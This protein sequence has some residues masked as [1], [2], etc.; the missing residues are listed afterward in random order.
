M[1]KHIL[2]LLAFIPAAFS[3]FHALPSDPVADPAA[4]VI[5]GKVRF[6]ILTP[7]TIRMEWSSDRKFED[8][9]SLTFINRKLPVPPY[10]KSL[11]NGWLEIQT[12]KLMIRYK[13]GS[14]K[15]TPD[16]LSIS[17]RMNGKEVKWSPGMP[18]NGNLRG[19]TRTLDGCDGDTR[20]YGDKGSLQLD[21]GI[22]SRDGWALVDDSERPLFDNSDWPWVMERSKKEC[23]DWYFFGYGFDYKTALADFTEISGNIAFPPRFAFGAWWSRYW[24]YTD[25]ELRDLVADFA[26]HQIPLDVLIV[27]MD[28]HITSLPEF[29]KD[30]K[31]QTDQAGESSGWTGLTWNKNYFPDPKQFLDWTGKQHLKTAL[32]LHPASGIQPHEACYE[33][34]AKAMGIDPASKKYVP[35]D[36]TDKTFARNYMDIIMHPM[37]KEGIDFWWLDWQQWGQTKIKGVNPTFYLN[38]VFF[39]DM[40]RMGKS[41][42]LLFHRYGGL[43]NHRYQI[44]F[45]GDTYITWKSL[46]YQPYFTLTAANV[47]YGYWSH[48]IGGHQ[49]GIRS[50]ELYT[51]WLQWGAFSPIL[52]THCTKNSTI[53][54]RIWAYAPEY[55][56]PMRNA[57]LWRYALV[58]YIYTNAH[59]AYET[60]ISLIH[61]LYYEYPEEENAYTFHD[62][63]MFGNDMLVAP[64]VRPI[65]TDSL[66]LMQKIWLPEGNWFEWFTGTPIKGGRVV[67]RPFTLNDI[68]VYVK[69]GSIIPMQRQVSRLTEAQPDPLILSVFP[70]PSG[71]CKIYEDEGDNNNFK[72]GAYAVTPVH[73]NTNDNNTITLVIEP[74]NGHFQGMITKRSYEMR[75]PCTFPPQSVMVNGKILP[76]S[77][78]MQPGTWNYNG[79]EVATILL[80]GPL[81]TDTKNE[82]AI[83]FQG[84][85]YRMLSEAKGKFERLM[86]FAKI[87]AVHNWDKSK[88]SNDN[89]VKMAQTG[90][91]MTYDPS[92]AA[93][94][95]KQFTTSWPELLDMIGKAVFSNPE[96]KPA[97]ELLKISQ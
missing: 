47:G 49:Q 35:F 46:E 32:N 43:G 86:T 37:Q 78:E 89:V 90:L 82:I 64:V 85:D 50:P 48:D 11:K 10:T 45:S 34:M 5:D 25:Q 31:L 96:L 65:G 27:D 40:D 93:E 18:D 22:I 36:I 55:Y 56:E 97:Y 84:N 68:P 61:P 16:N 42:P 51:R 63:Y 95:L 59:N 6:T 66:F 53:E 62:E 94:T 3:P 7:Q 67:E 12:G 30:G 26:S 1:K 83:T 38:Y 17:F 60:G 57:Y 70:G 9:A 79:N 80:T 23:Q 58:P 76:F 39:S 14:G 73:F 28:W 44:G 29:Y 77:S 91:K 13:S 15:F 19:T 41:R 8:H 21:K 92:A 4:I 87:L 54:R 75:F 69:A 33:A 20:Q 2:A 72:S 52:R 74:V 24:E 71:N 81:S 88:F